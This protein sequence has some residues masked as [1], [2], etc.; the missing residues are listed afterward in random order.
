MVA[1]EGD[2]DA[3]AV[4]AVI[5]HLGAD[6]FGT[7]F[8]DAQGQCFASFDVGGARQVYALDSSGFQSF[9]AYRFYTE[10]DRS[11]SEQ[12]LRNAGYEPQGL[13][14]SA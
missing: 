4:V 1:G 13:S 6:A 3:G 14:I 5:G 10:F 8:H 12:A 2:A 9:L 7:F 11:P